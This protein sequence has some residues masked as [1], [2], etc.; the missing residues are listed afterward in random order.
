[1]CVMEGAKDVFVNDA[2]VLMIKEQISPTS[3]RSR[4]IAY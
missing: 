1:M 2:T 4:A 3:R